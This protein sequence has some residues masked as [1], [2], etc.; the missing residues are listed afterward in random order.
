M[1]QE[2]PIGIAA[3]AEPKAEHGF[4]W[5]DATRIA[6]VAASAIAVRF[7]FPSVSLIAILGVLFGGWPIFREAA[8]NIAARRMTMELSMSIAIVAA[9]A[10]SEFFTALIIT[11]FVLVAEV[12][13]NMTVSR[14]RRA[15]RDLM[16][17]LPR[18]V[19]VRRA[20]GVRETSAEDLRAGDS[21]LVNP[22]GLIP[23]DGVVISGHS[24]VDQARVTGESMPAE[25]SPGMT[26]FAG[27]INQ[28]GAL[29]V[30]AD[31]IGRDTS[32]G[33]IIETV[34][35]AEQSRAPVQRL[36]DR[37]AGYLVYFTLATAALT[38]FLTHDI[39]STISVVI[40]AGA[41]GIAAGTPLA[42]LGGI[43]RAARLGAII[44]GGLHLET[45]GRVDTIVLDKT[46]T[47]TFG[48]TEVRAVLPAPG[49][50][51]AQ[52]LQAA[53][54]AE[55]RSEHPLGK[56]IVAYASAKC[57]PISEPERFDYT[58]GRGIVAIV[59]GATILVGNRALMTAHQVDA[60]AALG[61]AASEVMVARDG[62]L[63][64]TIVVADTVRPEARRAIHSFNSMSIRSILLTGD[65]RPVANA[66]GRQLGITEVEAGLLPEAKLARVK[67]LV[68]SGRIVAMVGDGVNDAP[69]LTEAS[70]G[71]AMGS[72]TDLA[73]ESAD[74]VLLGNDLVKF[75]ETI[76]IARWTRRIVWQ[77]FAGTIVVDAI[78][79][80]LAAMGFLNPPL[81]AFIHV[82]SELT[83][84][85][86]S[87]RLLPP[88]SERAT[89]P[90]RLPC[91]PAGTILPKAA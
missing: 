72:G 91:E 5:L 81:A 40:V 57:P 53:G 30:R 27:T 58:P 78:G 42:I 87:A 24:F 9:A 47:L 63:L 83:F 70:V 37:L 35:R 62:R 2:S 23:V 54:A 6:A 56:A 15:I 71:V 7:H 31:R 79:I 61:S 75:A 11:L 41:C 28:S 86:N 13:E 29:E 82:A 32:Y 85:A 48:R 16:D 10:I 22:G 52:V 90:S 80:V 44:K 88:R 1:D 55:L 84:I 50:S 49:I 67:D 45:L 18:T 64:G 74:V 76:A 19:I 60:P 26:V 77:N 8:E 3:S 17:F 65:A 34:E 36:A 14:G 68:A 4:G 69:A 66:V 51:E 25:K 59:D 39:R 46:G 12:L 38:L 43:G 89:E 20:G 73:R 33:K 21:V